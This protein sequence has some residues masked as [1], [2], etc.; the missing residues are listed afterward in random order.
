MTPEYG[1]AL[2]R[3]RSGVEM[4]DWN[5]GEFGLG[6]MREIEE[7]FGERDEEER[8]EWV[9]LVDERRRGFCGTEEVD[10]VVVRTAFVVSADGGGGGFA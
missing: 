7:V 6:G 10:I 4:P 3:I 1:K 2:K 8:L 5:E 9:G